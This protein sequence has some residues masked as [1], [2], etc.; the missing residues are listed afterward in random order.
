MSTF[1]DNYSSKVWVYFLKDRS[2]VLDQFKKFKALI[3]KELDEHIKCLRT[4]NGLELCGNDLTEL[5]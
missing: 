1:I 5:F 3:E 4:N 2:D